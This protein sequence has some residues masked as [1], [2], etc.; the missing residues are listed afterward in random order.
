MTRSDH[1][2]V[3]EGLSL[4]LNRLWRFG[5]VLSGRPDDAEELVQATCLKALEKSHQFQPGTHLDRWLFSIL[6][7]IWKNQLRRDKVRRG[8]GNVNAEETLVFDGGSHLE[9]NILARQVLTEVM[10]LP[11]AQRQTVFLVYV[12]GYS[13]REAAELLDIPIGTVMSRLAAARKAL[14]EL[15][16][17]PAGGISEERE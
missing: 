13:Y 1:N 3:R 10:A 5:L 4:H 6:S 11:E 8:E 15:N 2:I 17:A 16:E 12:E 7:S 14:S 9:T